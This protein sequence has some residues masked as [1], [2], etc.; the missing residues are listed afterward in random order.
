MMYKTQN[1][2]LWRHHITVP[3]IHLL[4]GSHHHA[5]AGGGQFL[6]LRLEVAADALKKM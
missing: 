3:L 2:N 4:I 6:N 5:G 1:I